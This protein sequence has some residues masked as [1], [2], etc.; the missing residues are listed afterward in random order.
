VCASSG[1]NWRFQAQANKNLLPFNLMLRLLCTTPAIS[2]ES[3][4]MKCNIP[5]H[6]IEI[7]MISSAADAAH[8]KIPSAQK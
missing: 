3:A 5:A 8:K 4:M 6:T 1:E 2:L 7:I